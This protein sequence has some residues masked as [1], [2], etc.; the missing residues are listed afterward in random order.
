MDSA[1]A[2]AY[3]ASCR[4]LASARDLIADGFRRQAIAAELAV[5]DPGRSPAPWLALRH[6]EVFRSAI[7]LNDEVPRATSPE[8]LPF[9]ELPE[10]SVSIAPP[11]SGGKRAVLLCARRA[12]GRRRP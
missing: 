12:S 6:K 3:E 2:G 9:L 5:A 7:C 11:P 4:G 10:A 8:L 1:V